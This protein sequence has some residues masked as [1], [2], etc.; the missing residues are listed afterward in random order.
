MLSCNQFARRSDYPADYPA[1]RDLPESE[2]VCRGGSCIVGPMG[3][4]LAAPAFDGEQV[5]VADLDMGDIVRAKFDFDPVGHYARP[6]VLRM[7]VDEREKRA[8]TW[9][10]DQRGDASD[11]GCTKAADADLAP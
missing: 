4:F 9:E 8:V 1:F 5:L 2:V 10:K 11:G 6:D 7:T 3:E